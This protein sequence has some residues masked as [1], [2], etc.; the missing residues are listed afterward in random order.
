MET[1]PVRLKR[2]ADGRS[3]GAWARLGLLL[4]GLL[5]PGA[6]AAAIQTQHVVIVS[7]DGGRYS[8]TLG[9]PTLA[10]HPRIGIDM[11]AIGARP[12]RFENIGSTTTNPGHS[13]LVTGT[14]QPIA[15]DGSERPHK[16]TIFEYLRKHNGTPQSAL[17]L[18]LRKPKL[19]VLAYSDHPDYGAAYGAAT[20]TSHASDL[21]VF[22][23]A[24]AGILANRPVVS[25]VHFGD[26]DLEGH[27][28][29]WPG[30]LTALR[31]ADSLTWQLWT[32]IQADPVMG[33]KTTMLISNDHGRHLDGFGGF[34]NHG[35]GCDGCRHIMLM[36]VGPDSRVGFVGAGTH[37]QRA[38]AR[39]AGW[40]LQVAMP[41]ADGV[42]LDELLLE[43]SGP[44]VGV[45]PS[46]SGAGD[47]TLE[48]FP[49]PSFTGVAVR[50][51]GPVAATARL[52]VVDAAGRR[53]ALAIPVSGAAATREWWWNGLD[54]RGRRVPPGTYLVRTLD[55][56]A[57]RTA[58]VTLLR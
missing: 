18:Y 22:T 6:A 11:A 3:L 46:R 54:E 28:N 20:P 43:P 27:A 40:L 58:R 14:L 56:R 4:T 41:L 1:R 19:D 35:D 29:D 49:N 55:A 17:R 36:M 25:L 32:A 12:A 8:E 13:A 44:I 15:N 2:A 48:V 23:A 16:P 47:L 34:Q 31:L 7:I 9:H 26:P 42:V 33:G 52:E 37:E 51:R 24:R 38:V 5:G 57:V 39:T 21:A 45:G 50:V 53:V 30:Y 10:Y